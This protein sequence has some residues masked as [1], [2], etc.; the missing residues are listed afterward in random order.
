MSL[1]E[2]SKSRYTRYQQAAEE[3]LA[4]LDAITQVPLAHRSFISPNILSLI[5]CFIF[6][7]TVE[8]VGDIRRELGVDN[9]PAPAL[10]EERRGFISPIIAKL[11]KK[12]RS[13]KCFT[14]VNF[15]SCCVCLCLCVFVWLYLCFCVRMCLRVCVSL[16]VRMCVSVCLSVLCVYE[17]TCVL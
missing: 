16:C 6:G 1:L 3:W 8:G 4:R 10:H 13:M 9:L 11:N 14:S 15:N 5:K 12:R 17:C 7:D 2:I